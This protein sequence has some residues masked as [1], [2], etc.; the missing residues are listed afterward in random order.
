MKTAFQ[1]IASL[2][3]ITLMQACPP[4]PCEPDS[5]EYKPLPDSVRSIL[6]YTDG[7]Q[8]QMRHSAGKVIQHVCSV[9]LEKNYF[10]CN[11]FEILNFKLTPNY[12]ISPIEISISRWDE[13]S[14]NLHFWF[15]NSHFDYYLAAEYPVEKVCLYLDDEQFVDVIGLK[16]N[17]NNTGYGIQ[18]ELFAD[19]L[20]FNQTHGIL[21]IVMSN[22]ETFIRDEV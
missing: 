5:V 8:Y 12:P 7:N 22:G 20:Y 14:Y 13:K 18:R 11:E 4:G 6:P 9:Q 19:S 21:K 17:N 1:L 10:E 3:L 16:N 2:L 15:S